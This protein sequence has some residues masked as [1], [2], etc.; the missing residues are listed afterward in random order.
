MNKTHT[1]LYEHIGGILP[2]LSKMDKLLIHE[3]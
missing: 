2:Y 1:F 3:I